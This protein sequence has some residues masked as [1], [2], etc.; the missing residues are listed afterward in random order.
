[1]IGRNHEKSIL[2]ISIFLVSIL[3]TGTLYAK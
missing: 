1:M 2:L 3:L